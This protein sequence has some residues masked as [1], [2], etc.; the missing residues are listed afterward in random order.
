MTTTGNHVTS[1][2]FRKLEIH[3]VDKLPT[4][5]HV[6]CRFDELQAE[7]LGRFGQVEGRLD[8]IDGRLDGIDGRLDGIDGTLQ[9][10]LNRLPP[11]AQP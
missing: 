4:R 5:K 8:G 1:E 10:I 2:Q 6:D 3:V 9:E 7:M 11:P